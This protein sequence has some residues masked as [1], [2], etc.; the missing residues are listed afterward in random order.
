MPKRVVLS[1]NK[2]WRMPVG[3][4][5]VARPH[6]WSNPFLDKDNAVATAKFKDALYNPG[7]C[8]DE[9]IESHMAYIR[10]NLDFLRG[11]D[12][13]CWCKLQNE[14][15]SH[16]PCHVDV[17]LEAANRGSIVEPPEEPK[18]AQTAEEMIAEVVKETVPDAYPF[19]EV[20]VGSG[21]QDTFTG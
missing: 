14:D 4:V 12:L 6:K 20:K 15:G 3:T 5:K 9:A 11:K 21:N 17:L 13:A 16:R 10:K 7:K 1:R 19:V 8:Q 18:V 2:G